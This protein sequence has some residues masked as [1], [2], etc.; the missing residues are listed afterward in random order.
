MV[1]ERSKYFWILTRNQTLFG[2]EAQLVWYYEIWQISTIFR[3][4]AS[5]NIYFRINRLASKRLLFSTRKLMFRE[6]TYTFLH[7]QTPIW[8]ADH[9][10]NH[11]QDSS[12]SQQL[13]STLRLLHKLPSR[14]QIRASFGNFGIH[15]IGSIL[16]Q[17][18]GQSMEELT[19]SAPLHRA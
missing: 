17:V 7:L 5:S 6:V 15:T 14:Y 19:T 12:K 16:H 2:F 3:E 9:W 18:R 11:F 4:Q 1:D 10:L 13:L 8:M